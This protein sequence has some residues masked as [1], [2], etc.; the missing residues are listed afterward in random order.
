M[1]PVPSSES[2]AS[3]ERVRR[4]APGAR[5]TRIWLACA[6][7]AA[8]VGAALPASLPSAAPVRAEGLSARVGADC[9]DGRLE[10]ILG[11]ATGSEQTFT[12]NG[13]E[14]GVTSTRTVPARGTATVR[15]PRGRGDAYALHVST[16]S[17][18]LRTAAGTFG[19]GLRTGEPGLVTSTVFTTGTRFTGMVD[20]R[21]GTYTGSAA[22]VRIPALAVTDSGTVLAVADAR[23]TGPGDL[24]VGDND[25]QLGLR[26]STD[27]GATWTDPEIVV[28]GPTSATGTGDASL[29]VDRQEDRVFLF[30]NRARKGAGY[31]RPPDGSGS[32]STDDPRS[33]HVEYVTSDDDGATWSAP[34]DLN[35]YVKDPAWKGVLSASGHG[36]QTSTGRLL[37]PIV[38]RDGDG[39]HALNLYSDD[40]GRTW[41]T[42]AVAGDGFNESKPV[43]RSD[44]GVAQNMRS[45]LE[46][47]RFHAVSPDGVR[48]FGPATAS[49]LVDPRVNADEIAYL[50]PGPGGT[51]P[52]TG[53]PRR[54]STA[55]FANPASATARRDLTV[56]LSG[57]DGASWPYDA[58]LRT[59]TA[60]YSA[61]AVLD[62]GSVGALYEIGATGGLRFARFT[63]DWLRAR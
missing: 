27:R 62:D 55:L 51:D 52:R 57:D 17:G 41:R 5:G 33:I 63:L 34:R 48:P 11:N 22:S 15:W 40:H 47:R 3:S 14:A 30:Y 49:D 53:A 60:G 12:V 36:V 31:H 28:H 2:R 24:G 10:L 19:C 16:P 1:R 42:G 23:V 45:D 32:N 25:I 37:Q 38:Y 13:P 35:P 6:A 20:A 4:S 26:R 46:P 18:Y 7:A 44:G 50:R 54:T 8:T 43:E 58:L 61:L 39:G 21:G 29:L 59:G 56:R 9:A